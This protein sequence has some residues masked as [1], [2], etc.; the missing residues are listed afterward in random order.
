MTGLTTST[1]RATSRRVPARALVAAAAPVAALTVWLLLTEVLGIRL[2]VASGATGEVVVTGLAVAVASLAA[3]LA[4]W[5]ALALLERL[6]DRTGARL[7]GLG[8]A[9]LLLASFYPVLAPGST[10]VDARVGL[11]LLHLVVALVVLGGLSRTTSLVSHR[12]S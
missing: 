3:A 2:E 6:L 11:A 10:A 1:T 7:W 12:P 4:G 8:G 5:G 9:L